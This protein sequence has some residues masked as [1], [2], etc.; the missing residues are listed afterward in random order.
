M[1]PALCLA[2]SRHATTLLSAVPTEDNGWSPPL[3]PCLENGVTCGHTARW[4]VTKREQEIW[5]WN[6]LPNPQG[7]EEWTGWLATG[8]GPSLYLGLQSCHQHDIPVQEAEISVWVQ[9]LPWLS[10]LT[11]PFSS[12]LF[13]GTLLKSFVHFMTPLLL[14]LSCAC[15]NDAADSFRTRLAPCLSLLSSLPLLLPI[16]QCL[17]GPASSSAKSEVGLG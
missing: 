10:Q 15:N 16:I 14:F 13:E 1:C 9:V 6:L 3:S 7:G 17:W 5:L 11:A 8:N 12:V 2:Q 4:H